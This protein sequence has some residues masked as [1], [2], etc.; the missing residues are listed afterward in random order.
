MDKELQERMDELIRQ[1]READREDRK[2]AEVLSLLVHHS[3]FSALQ[4]LLNKRLQSLSEEMLA[5][6]NSVD[7]LIAQEYLKGAMFGLI[8]ARDL[9]TIIVDSLATTAKDENDG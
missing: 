8:L 9:P 6:A 7:R 4:S 1:A 2:L 5:P 3:S